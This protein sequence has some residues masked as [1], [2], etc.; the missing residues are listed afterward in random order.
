M[1]ESRKLKSD[2]RESISLSR[3][4][5]VSRTPEG[6]LNYIEPE[7]GEQREPRVYGSDVGYTKPGHANPVMPVIEIIDNDCACGLSGESFD[8]HRQFV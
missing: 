6:D 1:R 7:V 4:S 8:S 3:T 2:K 5:R